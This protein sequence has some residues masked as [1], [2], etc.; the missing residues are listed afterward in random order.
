MGSSVATANKTGILRRC[1]Q[2]TAGPFYERRT[3]TGSAFCH[4]H[5]SAYRGTYRENRY[6]MQRNE[7]IV[8]S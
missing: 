6:V 5:V 2:V 7:I 3:T 1:A 8:A 4:E